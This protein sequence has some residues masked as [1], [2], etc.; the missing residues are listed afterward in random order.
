[1][2]MPPG[3]ELVSSTY[4]AYTLCIVYEFDRGWSTT[5]E[6]K[7]STL[8]MEGG[9]DELLVEEC[10]VSGELAMSASEVEGRAKEGGIAKRPREME[11]SQFLTCRWEVD[12]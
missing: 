2:W 3:Y 9:G 10:I 12:V 11:A 4:I 7:P 6:A 8:L 5:M 1:M